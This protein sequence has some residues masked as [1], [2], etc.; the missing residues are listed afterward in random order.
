MLDLVLKEA[1][2]PR[3]IPKENDEG[4]NK[5][6]VA[7]IVTVRDINGRDSFLTCVDYRI[8]I[9]PEKLLEFGGASK[10]KCLLQTRIRPRTEEGVRR[11]AS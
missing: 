2:K 8:D 9:D 1:L 4:A 6:A 11:G 10:M 3:P 5:K 7:I